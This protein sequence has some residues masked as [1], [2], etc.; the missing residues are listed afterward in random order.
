MID[1]DAYDTTW[2]MFEELEA[3]GVEVTPLIAAY[4]RPIAAEV[5]ELG[6]S[7]EVPES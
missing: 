1:R 2:S 4:V 5:V 7:L 3:L 6:R